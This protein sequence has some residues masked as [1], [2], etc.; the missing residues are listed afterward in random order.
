MD[1]AAHK[2]SNALYGTVYSGYSLLIDDRSGDEYA[3]KK[4]YKI[5]KIK[6][7]CMVDIRFTLQMEKITSRKLV[8]PKIKIFL[9]AFE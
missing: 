7:E 3:R 9:R 2:T 6:F 8:N 1:V 4:I 5:Q